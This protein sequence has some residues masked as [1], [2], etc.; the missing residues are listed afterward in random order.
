MIGGALAGRDPE[1]ARKILDPVLDR[2]M[3]GSAPLPR[4]R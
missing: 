3:A 1:E 4:H 2:M